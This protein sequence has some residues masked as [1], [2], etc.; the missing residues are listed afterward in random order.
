MLRGIPLKS[1][2]KQETETPALPFKSSVSN[3]LEI[4]WHVS[5]SLS[6]VLNPLPS[7]SFS[8]SV[9]SGTTT[10]F[11]PFLRFIVGFPLHLALSVQKFPNS[12]VTPDETFR[13]GHLSIFE[14]YHPA[15]LTFI[16]CT[17]FKAEPYSSL[18]EQCDL[19]FASRYAS[20]GTYTI[21]S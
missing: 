6:T 19:R 10:H 13:S 14:A 11:T 15:H 2:R 4:N 1:T 9:S 5:M 16:G 7:Q 12:E 20:C 18:D 8:L 17:I 21:T 3:N